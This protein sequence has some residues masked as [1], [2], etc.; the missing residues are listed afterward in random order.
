ML[1]SPIFWMVLGIGAVIHRVLPERA[2]SWWLIAIST[3]FL[4]HLEPVWTGALLGWIVL[5]YAACPKGPSS[6]TSWWSRWG[7]AVLVLAIFGFLVWFKYL[8][9]ARA[10]FS[11]AGAYI[12]PVGISYYTFKFIHYAIERRRELLPAHTFADFASYMLLLPIFSAG[13]IERFDHFKKHAQP[14]ADR[15]MV[16]DGLTRIAHGLIKK[17]VIAAMWV[18]LL[19]G[20][21]DTYASFIAHVDQLSPASVLRFL[22]FT[23]ILAYLD[24]SAYSDIAIGAARLFG[25]RIAENFNWPIFAKDIADFWRRWHM[26]L[27]AWC[28]SYIYLPV[29]GATRK[30]RVAAYATFIGMGLWHAGS[31]TWLLWGLYHGTGVAI[32][33]LWSQ[34]QRKRGW[35][36][37]K[38]P[39]R[40]VAAWGLT[41][42]FLTLSYTITST[43]LR[44]GLSDSLEIVRALI[45]G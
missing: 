10:R 5:F 36:K 7:T 16:I 35:H 44:G 19:M 22:F 15:S 34:F 12:L 25:Y 38:H 9:F 8:P 30:P 1:Q 4:L 21:H 13:P 40:S 45:P 3:A 6:S 23:Y 31:M 24:F 37:K 42:L 11:G 39:L 20:Q 41:L 28:R 26:S 18:P 27:A 43:H 29:M 2:R 32:F 17:F 33:T 14:Y